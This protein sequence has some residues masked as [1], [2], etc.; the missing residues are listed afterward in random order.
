MKQPI[1]NEMKLR[2]GQRSSACVC[3][4][5][6]F[7]LIKKNKTWM[8]LV[9]LFGREPIKRTCDFP[10]IEAFKHI[11]I[12]NQSMH[13]LCALHVYVLDWQLF[14]KISKLYSHGDCIQK[15]SVLCWFCEKLTFRQRFVC[16]DTF[17]H[18]HK[19]HPQI[20]VSL[21]CTYMNSRHYWQ[22]LARSFQ[23]N[24]RQMTKCGTHTIS[25]AVCIKY[26][27]PSRLPLFT[28]GK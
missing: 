11:G 26:S 1:E 7:R 28:F 15:W 2:I 4:S 10:G 14:G 16:S 18:T 12:G 3:G 19:R 8:L 6:W 9:T 25:Y 17:T 22:F 20:I 23:L 5:C 27:S 21:I 24:V 13:V